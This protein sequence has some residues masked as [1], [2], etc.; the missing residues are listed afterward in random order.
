[1]EDMSVRVCRTQDVYGRT[2]VTGITNNY[3][4]LLLLQESWTIDEMTA[5][6]ALY[7]GAL[8]TS[9]SPWLCP[10]LLFW[11]FFSSSGSC[12]C[13]DKIWSSYLYSFL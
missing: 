12:E 5:R 4:T 10:W 3:I 6:C 1:M 2:S 13:A 8:K 7:M 9:Y 11:I